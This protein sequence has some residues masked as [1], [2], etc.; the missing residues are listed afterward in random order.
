MQRTFAIILTFAM[1]LVFSTFTGCAQES[2]Q[3]SN[4]VS[5]NSDITKNTDDVISTET[6]EIGDW[7]TVEVNTNTDGQITYDGLSLEELENSLPYENVPQKLAAGMEV[8]VAWELVQLDDA[9]FVMLSEGVQADLEPLGFTWMVSEFVNDTAVQIQ[10]IENYLTMGASVMITSMNDPN[11]GSDLCAMCKEAGCYFLQ[12]GSVPE[13]Y[14]SMAVNVDQEQIG[15]ETVKM[16]QAWIDIVNPD[17]VEDEYH[18]ALLGNTTNTDPAVRTQTI[19][20]A[21]AEDPRTNLV[22]TNHDS[23]GIEV[24]YNAVVE[25]FTYDPSIRIVITFNPTQAIGANNYIAAMPGVDLAE[26]AIFF[27]SYTQEALD[28]IDQADSNNGSVMRGTIGF[29]GDPAWE[30]VTRGY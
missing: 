28:L 10:H 13:G 24:A 18:V 25:A 27:N 15:R 21:L 14:V 1:I 3:D 23:L 20:N 30:N 22:F 7:V 29:G 26:F 17:A 16:A 11:A 8:F 9:F 19:E 6:V 2:N 12:Q 5:P 4:N